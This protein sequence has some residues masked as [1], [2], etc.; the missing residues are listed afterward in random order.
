LADGGPTGGWDREDHDHFVKLVS[1]LGLHRHRPQEHDD[2]VS[3]D[4]EKVEALV[5]QAVLEIPAQTPET[6][7]AHW[8][9]CLRRRG[10]EHRKRLLVREWRKRRDER[11]RAEREETVEAE[12]R[13]LEAQLGA[14]QKRVGSSG[15]SAS[16][17]GRSSAVVEEAARKRRAA[18]KREE[19]RAWREERER[20]RE[21]DEEAKQRVRD[22]VKRRR[23]VE[24]AMEREQARALIE[25]RRL[26]R[27]EDEERRKRSAAL[28]AASERDRVAAERA[29]REQ[30]VRERRRRDMERSAKRGEERK[31]RADEKENKEA[32]WQLRRESKLRTRDAE[33]KGAGRDRGGALQRLTKAT[34]ASRGMAHSRQ[35]LEARQKWIEA[36]AG[37]HDSATHVA[38]SVGSGRAGIAVPGWRRGL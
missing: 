33:A 32:E 23:E 15:P 7:R 30:A 19:V 10:R 5:R 37:G 13:A 20:R 26:E 24:R 34:A 38:P 3:V 36:H 4:P 35:E 29:E 31:R 28:V 16:S 22:R 17:K 2:D 6:A 1:Q 11:M 25:R 21:R 9:F 14:Q 12:R 27:A 18:R 8:H